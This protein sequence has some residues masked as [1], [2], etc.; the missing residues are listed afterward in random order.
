[1]DFELNESALRK[2]ITEELGISRDIAD[3]A[4]EV[5]NMLV[6]DISSNTQNKR[7]GNWWSVQE[8]G[9]TFRFMDTNVYVSYS[10]TD[11]DAEDA[12]IAETFGTS[13]DASSVM[14]DSGSAFMFINAV[15]VK[16]RLHASQTRDGIQHEL[17]HIYQ[18]V[19]SGERFNDSSAYAEIV[20]MMHFGDRFEQKVGRLLYGCVRSEQDGFVNGMYAYLMSIPGPFRLDVMKDTEC[21]R[22]YDEMVSVYSEIGDTGEFNEAIRKFGYTSNMVGKKIR[23]FAKKIARVVSKVQKDKMAKQGLRF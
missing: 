13:H 14:T 10:C 11:Y 7:K 23:A 8:G 4:E 22:L 9:F 15:S 18:Q 2:L 21:A 6:N 3:K 1:M 5:Y 20:T 17:E 19:M 16:G 12:D